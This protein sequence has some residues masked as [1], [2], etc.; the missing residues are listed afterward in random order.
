[1]VLFALAARL[2]LRDRLDG[3]LPGGRAH[4]TCRMNVVVHCVAIVCRP[5]VLECDS[6]APSLSSQAS[7]RQACAPQLTSVPT[8]RQRRAVQTC[9]VQVYKT[10]HIAT[11]SCDNVRGCLC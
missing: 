10:Y 11:T 2:V 4:D 9:R 7:A 8:P 5:L 1:M 6:V 3:L